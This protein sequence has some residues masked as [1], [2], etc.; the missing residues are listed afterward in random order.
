MKKKLRLSDGELYVLALCIEW[1]IDTSAECQNNIECL[2]YAN[3][4]AYK[5]NKKID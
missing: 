2:N 1:Y 3:E 5:I 4:L